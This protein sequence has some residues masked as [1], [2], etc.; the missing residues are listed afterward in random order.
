[1]IL[2]TLSLKNFRKFR[3]IQLEFP[4]G[5]TGVIGLNGVG[6]S[7]IFEAIAWALY[8]PVAART[9][10]DRIKRNGTEHSD[11]C[12]V[13]LE[14]LFAD[15]SFRVVRE[16]KGK[17]QIASAIA[18]MD[19]KIV[20][21]G[22]EVVSKFIQ[23]KLGMDFKSFYTSIFA[24]Q[25]ELNAL[26]TMNASERR[27]LILRMLGIQS[28]DQVI[29]SIHSD[30][31]EKKSVINRIESDIIDKD[32]GK[33]KNFLEEKIASFRK[34][35]KEITKTRN[36][37]KEKIVNIRQMHEKIN[38]LKEQTKQEYE[39][40]YKK[41]EQLDEQKIQYERKRSIEDEI[42]KIKEEI[43]EKQQEAQQ[44]QS[45][46]GKTSK[47]EIEIN[48][49]EQTK[50]TNQTKLEQ[51]SK[52]IE[53]KKMIMNQFNVEKKTLEEKKR[54]ITTIGA[55]AK[56]PT[57]ER[58]LGNQYTVLL[59]RY[60]KIIDEIKNNRLEVEKEYKSLEIRLQQLEKQRDAFKKKTEYL[61]RQIIERE[62]LI[63]TA[64]SYHQ[65]IQKIEEKLKLKHNELVKFRKSIFDS[66]E[67]ATI[68]K[69][70]K[71]IYTSYQTYLTKE[72]DS[73]TSLEEVKIQ[74]ERT[75]GQ[76]KLILQNIQILQQKIREI[77]T[78]ERQL[79][80]YKKHLQQLH[81]LDEIMSNFRINLISQIRPTLSSY[82]SQLFEQLTEG[83]YSEIEV[84]E[85]YNLTVVDEGTA[86]EIKRFSGGEE[87]LA[88]LCI[89][90][91]I[92]EIITERA[93]SLINFVILDEIFGS[94][95]TIRRQNII[96][97]LNRF[98]S[99]FRQIFLITHIEDI[100]NLME[101]TITV[102]EDENR[103]SKI[104]IE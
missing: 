97:A 15:N 46:I 98:S 49:L 88:N 83:K 62:K 103:I 21:N 18:T 94:Q 56:C 93:G 27:P 19:G 42:K 23:R 82:A 12:R 66:L 33:K 57:C 70:I 101:H 96:K 91:A 44:L 65:N 78:F 22:A 63:S 8:G 45:K 55:S 87:D 104:K 99:K 7:T 43:Q 37:L 48:K 47:L 84:D 79:Q 76:L 11:P 39:R 86:Y 32:G 90:L 40:I 25:K 1:M 10:A 54:D 5:V 50:Q 71:E 67:Y 51:L 68:R 3:D 92:S 74:H 100:K 30:I 20:A 14:F 85:Q 61:N 59:N 41:K 34:E 73:R 26:S 72:N 6:K 53:Q 52:N 2:K 24:K 13:E 58:V 102:L 28:L 36:Q 75:D 9:S 17:N 60:S 38:K 31:R 16:L 89:R 69:K 64:K 95:D 77:Q 4:D 81:L 80:D 29:A 35:E